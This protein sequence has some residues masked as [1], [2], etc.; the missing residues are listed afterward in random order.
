MVFLGWK[1]KLHLAE[2]CIL[3]VLNG[4]GGLPLRDDSLIDEIDEK[5]KD[6]LFQYHGSENLI[7]LVYNW[8][9]KAITEH[10]WSVDHTPTDAL[11][12]ATTASNF[13]NLAID[14]NN[15]SDPA[16]IYFD[17]AI[18]VK[19]L[20]IRIK[21]IFN[22]SDIDINE[23]IKVSRFLLSQSSSY[24]N[25]IISD[26]KKKLSDLE[27]LFPK[28][29]SYYQQ[30]KTKDNPKL[31]IEHENYFYDHL[32]SYVYYIQESYHD[33]GYFYT[34]FSIDTAKLYFDTALAVVSDNL[35]DLDHYP[36][37]KSYTGT[38]YKHYA[39]AIRYSNS[40]FFQDIDKRELATSL[41]E[42]A[43]SL[44]LYKEN[45]QKDN[46]YD[47]N[48]NAIIFEFYNDYNDYLSY[49]YDD[50]DTFASE[51]KLELIKYYLADR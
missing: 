36:F 15:S 8:F 34:N 11:Q 46:F 27:K 28:S 51:K 20:L 7:Y 48:T 21:K 25:Q 33:L 31:D 49:Y 29:H 12:M 30:L 22:D 6:N 26:N 41:Y 3:V 39:D 17:M 37:Y 47:E 32:L 19:N 40:S 45:S 24:N 50:K 42:K 14:N 23:Q 43:L 16:S 10:L 9:S 35:V 5:E 2:D 44:S 1:P 38:T 13:I 4:F 18:R